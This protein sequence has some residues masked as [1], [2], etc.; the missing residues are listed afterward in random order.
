MAD[1]YKTIELDAK[2]TPKKNEPYMCPQQLAYFYRILTNQ[3]EELLSER[4]EVLNAVRM[5]DK[6]EAVGVGD[7]SDAATYNQDITMDLRMSDRSNKLLQKVNAALDRIAN[8]T[9]GYSVVSGDEIGIKRMM[10]RPLATMTVEEQ[11][12]Y[13]AR[14]N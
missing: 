3:R 7:D 14:K 11:E 10:A 4:D 12:E 6:T 1:N 8:G 2:Y 13:E 9:F 5:A